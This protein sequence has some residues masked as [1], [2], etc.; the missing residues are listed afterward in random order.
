MPKRLSKLLRVLFGEKGDFGDMEKPSLAEPEDDNDS[1]DSTSS[2][3]TKAKPRRKKTT[4]MKKTKMK[5]LLKIRNKPFLEM[6]LADFEKFEFWS[7]ADF[8]MSAEEG[9]DFCM[10][11]AKNLDR[12]RYIV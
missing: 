4:K 8:M 1:E 3:T 11:R 2:G 10:E 7:N 5:D 12:T 6:S 9:W